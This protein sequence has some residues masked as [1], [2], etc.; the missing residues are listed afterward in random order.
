[1]IRNNSALDPDAFFGLDVKI[2][3]VI[4]IDVTSK[5]CLQARVLM[6]GVDSEGGGVYLWAY[7]P[8]CQSVDS[9]I[10]FLCLV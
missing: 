2:A 5:T 7:E 6:I 4:A 1:M 8:N 3:F 9:Q 10:F